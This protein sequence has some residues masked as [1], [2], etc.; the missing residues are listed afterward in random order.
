MIKSF[1]VA[2]VAALALAA[3]ATPEERAAQAQAEM[4]GMMRVYG[5]ACERLGYARESDGWRDCITRLDSRDHYTRYTTAP[6]F[7]NCFGHRGF[8]SCTTF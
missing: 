1:I 6:T 5:P 2:A 4:E 7:T 3:C 8:F